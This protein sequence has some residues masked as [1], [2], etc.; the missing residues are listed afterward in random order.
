MEPPAPGAARD[1]VPQDQTAHEADGEARRRLDAYTYLSAPERLKHLAIMRV[2]C[3]TLLADL[4]VPDVLAKLRQAGG[5][6]AGLD[7]DTLRV[8][9]ITSELVRQHV[10]TRGRDRRVGHVD[11]YRGGRVGLVR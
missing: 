2:F 3:G 7:A 4:A 6:A 5:R 8:P 9:I 10:R 1:A 11:G